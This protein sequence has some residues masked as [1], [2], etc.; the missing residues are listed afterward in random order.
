MII[1]GRE[2]VGKRTVPNG[3]R[4]LGYNIANAILSTVLFVIIYRF[5]LD[6]IHVFWVAWFCLCGCGVGASLIIRGIMSFWEGTRK[7][8]QNLVQNL[9][10]GALYAGLILVG[11]V[12]L[13]F[14]NFF[15]GIWNWKLFL[16][17]FVS[18]KFVVFLLSDYI[19]DS[20]TFQN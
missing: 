20:I 13:M 2:E 7:T 10:I 3:L 16:I 12:D 14:D 9:L 15:S 1:V 8:I 17:V 19:A 18:T 4:R 6:S 5:I 11:F